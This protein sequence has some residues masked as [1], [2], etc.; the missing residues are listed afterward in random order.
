MLGVG[1]EET[2]W[3]W[4][5]NQIITGIIYNNNN[6]KIIKATSQL[7]QDLQFTQTRV[8]RDVRY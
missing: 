5:T 4:G 6:N 8:E 2:K 1:I 3:I 7:Y